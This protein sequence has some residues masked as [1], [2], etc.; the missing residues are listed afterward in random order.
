RSE[1][2]VVWLGIPG[3]GGVLDPRRRA[4]LAG[5]E[6]GVSEQGDREKPM[7]IGPEAGAGRGGER[8]GFVLLLLGVGAVMGT[9]LLWLTGSFLMAAALTVGMIG[10][11]LLMGWMAS[12]SFDRRR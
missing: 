11:M 4:A 8:L 2:M 1:R 10:L 6:A 12:G 9:L 5:G 3:T 7:D